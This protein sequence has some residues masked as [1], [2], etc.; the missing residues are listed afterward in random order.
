MKRVHIVA[1]LFGLLLLVATSGRVCATS[2][3]PTPTDSEELEG[4]DGV[5][6]G[7]VGDDGV[8]GGPGGEETELLGSA[9][10][11]VSVIPPLYDP[12]FIHRGCSSPKVAQFRIGQFGLAWYCSD[13]FPLVLPVWPFLTPL[14]PCFVRVGCLLNG[15]TA[16]Y[17]NNVGAWFCSNAPVPPPSELPE[18]CTVPT[19]CTQDL[20]FNTNLNAWVCNDGGS[21]QFD[22][23]SFSNLDQC[24]IPQSCPDKN[25]GTSPVYNIN[26][27]TWYC[28]TQIDYDPCYV[29]GNGDTC[30]SIYWDESGPNGRGWYC[31][32]GVT[33]PPPGQTFAGCQI[34]TPCNGPVYSSASYDSNVPSGP[35]S[36]FGAWVRVITHHST[37]KQ[38]HITSSRVHVHVYIVSN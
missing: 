33:Q 15:G 21:E 1:A 23:T 37:S 19:G 30:P 27:Q 22:A 4:D 20:T 13:R 35:Y 3:S 32:N 11:T 9:G 2:P 8:A 38:P 34:H 18:Q 25:T 6:G 5:A 28:S 26:L 31:S 10:S 14:D 24:Q 12:C 17:N 16:A 7:P 36:P 29:V